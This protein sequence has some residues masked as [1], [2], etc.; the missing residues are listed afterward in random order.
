[1]VFHTPPPDA[2]SRRRSS[3]TAPR[4]PSGAYPLVPAD[5]TSPLARSCMERSD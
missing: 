5:I 3:G 1:V 4:Q 2:S